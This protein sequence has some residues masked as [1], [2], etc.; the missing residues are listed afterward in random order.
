MVRHDDETAADWVPGFMLLHR[1][2]FDP[3]DWPAADSAKFEAMVE[4]WAA[5]LTAER[6]TEAEAKRASR[7]LVAKPP[8]YRRDHLPAI[9]AAV[10]RMRA[11]H[12]TA[13]ASL[14]EA[15]RLA[16]GCER[17]EGAGW[18]YLYDPA[19]SYAARRPRAVAATCVCALGVFYRQA[20]DTKKHRET[21]RG[22][23]TLAD[24]I[25]R[26]GHA[27][28]VHYQIEPPTGEAATRAAYI[29]EQPEPTGGIE[30]L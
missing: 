8:K 10:R 27:N 25:A 23:P 13:A 6:V 15:Q 29:G 16:A 26:R 18:V 9:L 3:H 24:V 30:I 28:G 22:I 19:P 5:A 12:D 4:D 11:D 7:R 21:L 1:E 20:H 17:C 2:R 14:E